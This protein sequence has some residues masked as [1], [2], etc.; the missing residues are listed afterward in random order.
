MYQSPSEFVVTVLKQESSPSLEETL[1]SRVL[2]EGTGTCW[3]LAAMGS[4]V[5][6]MK[7]GSFAPSSFEVGKKMQVTQLGACLYTCCH[8]LEGCSHYLRHGF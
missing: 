5:G 7:Q 8:W 6:P 1:D 4:D 2:L 3:R